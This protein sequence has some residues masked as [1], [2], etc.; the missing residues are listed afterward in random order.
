MSTICQPS[1]PD[2]FLPAPDKPW[3]LISLDWSVAS[4]IWKKSNQNNSVEEATSIYNCGLIKAISPDTKCFIYHN[5]ELALQALESQRAVMYNPV[6]ANWFLQYTDGMGHKNGVVY[7][8]PGGPGDQFFWDYSVP[9]AGDYYITSV[10]ST[11]SNPNVSGTFTDDVNGGD[12]EHP[13]MPKN[14]NISSAVLAELQFATQATNQR[15]IEAAIAS[16]K[17]V[18]QAFGAQDDVG[19]G[20]SQSNC[21]SFMT[22]YCTVPAQ[23]QRAMTMKF[24]PNNKIQSVA[25]FLII[26]PPIAY[27]GFGWESDNRNWDPIFL[28]QVGEPS[29]YC[30]Q[31]SPGVFER[32]W[33]YGSV[34]LDCNSWTAT[35]PHA[36]GVL[37]A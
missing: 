5:M 15:L 3:G 22:T 17:Y 1:S 25:G 23:T 27:L 4:N 2:Y 31:T 37:K 12:E 26:R 20:V 8:E 35:V 10:I 19:G 28:T 34:T 24:D 6:Y 36:E 30:T 29:S 14:I 21:A 32:S 18:W 33:T 7:N 9:E 13:N 11:L 16:G